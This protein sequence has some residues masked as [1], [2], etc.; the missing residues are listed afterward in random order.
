MK[1]TTEI[2]LQIEIKGFHT[3]R[4]DTGQVA[5]IVKGDVGS[6]IATTIVPIGCVYRYI[7]ARESLK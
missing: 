3:V 6:P 1:N 2:V 4:S 5:I 7:F